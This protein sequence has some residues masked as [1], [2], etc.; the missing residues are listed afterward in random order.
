MASACKVSRCQ[1]LPIRT[2]PLT[3]KSDSPDVR[4]STGRH[5]N[6]E[7]DPFDTVLFDRVVRFAGQRVAAVVADT[8]AA[9]QRAA[10]LVAVDYE[11]LPSVLD[12]EQAMRLGSPLVHGD[13][14]TSAGI[15]DPERNIAVQV[16]GGVG[17]VAAGLAS[18][19]AVVS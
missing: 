4:Y 7:T 19:A 13:K 18:A 9:A 17:D 12:P 1:R 15:A 16:H 14:D 6:I 8:A 2:P 10:D 11:P 3:P 5:E